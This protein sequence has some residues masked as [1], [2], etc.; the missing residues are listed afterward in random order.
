MNLHPGPPSSLVCACFYGGPLDGDIG[1][2][3]DS[4][5]LKAR[6]RLRQGTY[7]LQGFRNSAHQLPASVQKFALDFAVYQWEPAT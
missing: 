2:P 3:T 4:S 1:C 5:N 6:I 7:E